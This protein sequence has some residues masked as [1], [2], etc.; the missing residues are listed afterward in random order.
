MEPNYGSRPFLRADRGGGDQRNRVVIDFLSNID[1][2]EL[3]QNYGYWVI[4]LGTFLEGETI[5]IIGGVLAASGQLSFCGVGLCAFVGSSLSDQLMFCIGKY[6]GNAIIE[7]FPRLQQKKERVA[8]LLRKYDI[9]LILG[10]RFIYGIRNITPIVLG[11]SHVP[12]KRFL[13]L[14]LS[15]ALAWAFLFTAAGYYFGQAIDGIL[16][17]CGISVLAIIVG[18]ILVVSLFLYIA[19]RRK[20]AV[21]ALNKLP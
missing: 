12:H 18:V 15:G 11:L 8:R 1:W 21:S 7:R 6:K 9:F 10:F 4:L 14:N 2:L 13:P 17:V 5:V 16:R 19:R 3:L 20:A